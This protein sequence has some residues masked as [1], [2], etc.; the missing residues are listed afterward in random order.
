[1]RL[2]VVQGLGE[3]WEGPMRWDLSPL[4]LLQGQNVVW[5]GRR[6]TFDGPLGWKPAQGQIK[7]RFFLRS[8]VSKA[9]GVANSWD[10]PTPSS[11]DA[12]S[13]C[14]ALSPFCV[15]VQEI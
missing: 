1:M 6:L 4:G 2:G 8:Q 10:I 5:G 7:P 3:V 11:L 13:H 15:K 12:L 9:S 14:R